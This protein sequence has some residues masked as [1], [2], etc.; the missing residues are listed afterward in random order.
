MSLRLFIF[1]LLGLFSSRSASAAGAG[2]RGPVGH[3]GGGL[4]PWWILNGVKPDGPIKDMGTW[5][6]TSFS[7]KQ[8]REFGIN[9]LGE[10][11]DQKRFES[12]LKMVREGKQL[13]DPG[14]DAQ[15]P[16]QTPDHES[17]V[18]YE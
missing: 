4:P 3:N 2:F 17:S 15:V 13:E 10:V 16:R 9:D 7:H 11:Q 5:K 8:Q 12:A 14:K 18:Q 1:M 6:A